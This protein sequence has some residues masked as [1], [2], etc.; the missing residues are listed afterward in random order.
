MRSTFS[1]EARIFK[2]L[3]DPKRLAILDLLRRG[4]RCACALLDDLD[5]TQSG[6]SYHMKILVDSGLV[7]ARQEGRWTHYTIS[8]P[9][10]QRIASLVLSMTDPD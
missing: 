5:L 1:N 9:G 4:E 3:S 2:S 7:E 10:R 8:E 6:L